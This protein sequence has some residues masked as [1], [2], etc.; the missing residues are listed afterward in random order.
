MVEATLRAVDAGVA[1]TRGARA[2]GKAT[3]AEPVAALYEQGR[4][5]HVGAFAALEDQMCGFTAD[6]DR[7]ARAAIRRT[8]STRWSGR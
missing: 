6:F 7:A 8:G 4:V 5:H 3:R 2:R 1:F